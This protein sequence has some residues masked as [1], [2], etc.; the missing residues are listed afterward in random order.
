ML[1]LARDDKERAS[2]IDEQR[3]DGALGI[4]LFFSHFLSAGSDPFVRNFFVCTEPLAESNPH[5]CRPS[6]PIMRVKS[7]AI[8]PKAKGSVRLEAPGPSFLFLGKRTVGAWGRYLLF[9]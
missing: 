1:H 7:E 8:A 6:E 5:D 4:A 3:I 2:S 9:D